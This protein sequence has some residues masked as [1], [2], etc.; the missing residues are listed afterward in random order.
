MPPKRAAREYRGNFCHQCHRQKIKCSR[1]Q[2]CRSCA[3]A[4]RPCTYAVRDR[5]VTVSESYLKSLESALAESGPS[6]VGKEYP[7]NALRDGLARDAETACAHRPLDPLVENSTVELFVSKL[8][9]TPK[10]KQSSGTL[11]SRT[12]SSFSHDGDVKRESTTSPMYEYF[13]LNYDTSHAKCTFKLPP[14]P[15]A[16]YLLDQFTIYSGYDWHWFRLNTFRRRLDNV[17]STMNSGES[18]DRIWLCRLLVVFALGSC[19]LALLKVPYEESSIDHLETLN[20]V[21]FCSFFLDRQKTA[22]LYAGLSTRMCNMLQLHKASSSLDCS[23][24]EREHRKRVWWS[25]FC[26]DRMASSQM[27]LLPALQI[28]QVDLKYPTQAGLTPEELEEFSDPDF[29]TARIQLTIIQSNAVSD[30]C[31]LGQ[32]DSKDTETVFRPML[33]RLD[34]WKAGLP[35]H[36]ALEIGDGLPKLRGQLPFVR[37]LANLYIRF[38]QCVIVLLRPLLLRQIACIFSKEKSNASQE[39][40]KDMNNTCLRSARSNLRIL[41]DVRKQG[42]LARLGIMENMHLFSSLMVLC[43]AMSIN[44]RHPD[45]F[46]KHSDDAA[47]YE[48]GKDVL[49]DMIRA[50]SLAARGH[51]KMLNEIEAL[52]HCIAIDGTAK[53]DLMAEQ[54]DIDEWMTQL[55]DGENVSDVF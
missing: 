24:V 2:P 47:T 26:M 16:I 43:L 14:Y 12:R 52:G 6:D 25:T 21:A 39:D 33:R 53:G 38:N 49:C 18:K 28:D 55:F 40:L 45:S 48:S 10:L 37:S 3:S 32:D 35:A 9:Q 50:G 13:A 15:Y 44:A 42:L 23:P 54:W 22:Y 36:M 51:E 19:A 17:Y 46:Y 41:I 11:G 20:L 8:K 30:V 1:E 27:G 4:K 29:L 31:H 7:D 5:Q 34:A